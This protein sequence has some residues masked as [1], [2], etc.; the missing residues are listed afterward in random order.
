MK[1]KGWITT[2]RPRAWRLKCNKR[3]KNL[4]GW[5]RAIKLGDLEVERE[6]EDSELD[7]RNEQEI[8]EVESQILIGLRTWKKKCNRS[9]NLRKKQT[10]R[11]KTWERN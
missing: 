11:P 6:Q 7:S 3:T 2:R 1:S 5:T 4:K 10:S 8:H 9:R